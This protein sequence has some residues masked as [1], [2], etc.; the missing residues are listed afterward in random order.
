M[1][2]RAASSPRGTGSLADALARVPAKLKTEARWVCW[3]REERGGKTTK[4]PV[5][6]R[7]G[8]MAKSTGPTTW[9]T[10]EDAVAAVGRRRCDGVGL[11]FGPDRAYTGFDLDHVVE[12]A[13]IITEVPP[14]SNEL[15]LIFRGF[16]P[17]GAERSRKGQPGGRVAEMYDHDRYFTVTGNVFEGHGTVSA[18]PDVVERAHR[19]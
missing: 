1:T 12:E 19:T 4:L 18:N 2:E 3:R 7:T 9:A 11:V 15:R 14:S 5:D 8:R 13:G 17:E 10:F 6:A 16:K